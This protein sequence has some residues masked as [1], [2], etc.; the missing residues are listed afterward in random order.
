GLSITRK[1]AEMMGG[2]ISVESEYG[3]GSVFTVVIKQQYIDDSV[4]GEE[5]VKNLNNFHYSDIDHRKKH[6]IVRKRMPHA[7]VLVVDDVTTNLEVARG[8]LNR[9]GMQIDCVNSGRE[10]VNAVREEKV[11]YD[12]IFM[13]HMMPEMDGIEATKIIREDIG[14]EYAKTVP[15]I[16]LTANAI[17]GNEEMFL[18][19]GF[20]AFI[21]KPIDVKQLDSILNTWIR[22]SIFQD[23]ELDGVDFAE[24]IERY[25]NE[26]AYLELIRSYHLHTPALLEKLRTFGSRPPSNNGGG[27]IPLSEYA[28]IVHGIKGSSYGISA[29]AAGKEAEKLEKA[30]KDGNL[31]EVAAGNGAFIALMES[32]LDDLGD[33]LHKTGHRETK[34][35]KSVPDPALLS[36]LLE[37]AK[38]YQAGSM[39]QTI[40]QLESFEYETGGEL[41]GWIRDQMDDLEYDAIRERLEE[42]AL[43]AL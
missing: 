1:I 4:I 8:M 9:Y 39:E 35:E 21:S 13:D 5:V 10:A 24:G 28:I 30:A 40:K 12:A 15:V 20:Q 27:G 33:L 16:A 43:Q 41:V 11:K 7:H 32:L 37:A 6:Q 18:G 31:E 36:Q 19:K 34:P 38:E 29:N 26:D 2:S 25:A 22:D 3:K 17:I 23:F 14:T 42:S